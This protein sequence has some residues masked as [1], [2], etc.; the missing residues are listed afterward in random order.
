VNKR[1][2]GRGAPAP[3][4]GALN[5]RQRKALVALAEKPGTWQDA[6]PMT[7]VL[8]DRDKRQAVNTL[9]ALVRRG[10]ADWTTRAFARGCTTGDPWDAESLWRITEA[11][12]V[13]ARRS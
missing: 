2:D 12:L 10:L 3:A 5:D 11:G 13:E 7:R 1:G 8:G 6:G 4:A 9:N